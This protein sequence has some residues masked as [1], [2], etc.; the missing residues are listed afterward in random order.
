MARNVR[1]PPIADIRLHCQTLAM[2][3]R[4]LQILGW[5]CICISLACVMMVWSF[6]N[7][8]RVGGLVFV[9]L[10]VFGF[11]GAMITLHLMELDSRDKRKQ[12]S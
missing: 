1:Y 4:T 3:R 2:K 5:I 8:S 11:P 7:D 10:I 12:D 6:P 9:G